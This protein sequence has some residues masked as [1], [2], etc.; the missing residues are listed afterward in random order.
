ME[1]VT[2]YNGVRHLPPN[3]LKWERT[4]VIARDLPERATLDSIKNEYYQRGVVPAQRGLVVYEVSSTT[5]EPRVV[6]AH[7][8]I[9]ESDLLSVSRSICFV[10]MGSKKYEPKKKDFD[11]ALELLASLGEITYD[12][13]RK[14]GDGLWVEP[15]KVPV[16]Q[17]ISDLLRTHMKAL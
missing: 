3:V 15:E 9:S 6:I 4:G 17:D 2:S 8:G 7:L 13:A 16:V 14:G 1:D 12:Q 10:Q 5:T 11:I